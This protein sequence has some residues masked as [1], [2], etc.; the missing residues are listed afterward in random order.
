MRNKNAF[1]GL[2]FI[3]ILGFHFCASDSSTVS[4]PETCLEAQ[5]AAIDET[6]DKPS[7]GTYTLYIDGDEAQPWDAYC[8]DMK[9]SE[10]KEFI[11]VN[12]VDNY[13]QVST[14]AGITETRF[15]RYRIDPTRLE[16][17]L[18]DDTFASTN[19]DENVVPDEREHIPA[20]WAQFGTASENGD[21]IAEALISLKDTSFVLDESVLENDFFCE[22]NMGGSESSIVIESDL[23]EVS[24]LAGDSVPSFFTKTVADCD[25]FGGID[26]G[27]E[28]FTDG[29]LPVQYLR[30]D[31]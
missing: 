4:F 8:H 2:I 27:S 10:P 20:G 13:S 21:A 12:E 18:L 3:A 11:T 14:P 7:N 15:R 25:N 29:K 23:S 24:L 28:N 19:G 16:I 30:V 9:R 1:K 31:N 5:E 26:N 6:G 17:D 22:T